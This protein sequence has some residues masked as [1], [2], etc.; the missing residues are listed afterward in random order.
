MKIFYVHHG[1]RNTSNPPSQ[2]DDI[3]PL[4]VKDAKI[5]AELMKMIGKKHNIKAIYTSPYLRC[6]KT[7]KIINKCIKVP[8]YEEPRLNEF[9]NVFEAIEGGKVVSKTETWL[10]CQTRIRAAI[11]DIVE[12]HD[13]KDMVVCVTSGVNIT[14]FI[15]LAYKIK[16]SESLPFPWVPSCSPICFEIDKSC[17]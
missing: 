4:G 10:E 8:I 6:A 13:D 14:A 1:L 11:K 15:S 7:A 9:K 12:K 5:V 17:F 16:P 3:K 2:R